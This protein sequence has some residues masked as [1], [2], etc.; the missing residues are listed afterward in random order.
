[1]LVTFVA[2]VVGGGVAV[3]V[4]VVAVVVAS[5][6]V[7]C[8]SVACVD[9]PVSVHAVVCLNAFPFFGAFVFALVLVLVAAMMMPRFGFARARHFAG[10]ADVADVADV[11]G[12]EAEARS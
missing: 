9:W 12:M 2:V 11:V 7:V 4:V 6:L 3:V 1:M 5:V 10:D 8:V